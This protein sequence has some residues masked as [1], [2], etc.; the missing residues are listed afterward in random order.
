MAERG[1]IEYFCAN[2][3]A[4]RIVTLLLILLSFENI[5]YGQKSETPKLV[6]GIVVDQM[7]YDYLYRFQ[8]KYGKDGFNK[9]MN[10]GLNCR[11]TRYNYVPT[12][13]GPGHASIYTGTTP[14]NHGIV[15]NDWYDAELKRSKNCVED[16]NYSTVGGA[17]KSGMCSPKNLLSNTIADQLKLTYPD[18]KVVSA[19]IKNRGAIL[20]GGHLSDGSYW[21]DSKTGNFITSTFY[22]DVLPTWVIS[23]NQKKLADEYMKGNW[24]TLY[25]ISTYTESD[26]DD[27]PYEHLMPGKNSPTFPYNL[28]EMVAASGKSASSFFPNTPFANTF[29]TD[30]AME[31][32]LNEGLG[33]DDQTDMLCISYSSPDIIGHAFGPYSKEIEDTYLRLD[34]DLAKLIS[35]LEKEVGKKN[36]TLFITADHA[37]VPVPEFLIDHKLPGGYCYTSERMKELGEALDARFGANLIEAEDNLNVFFNRG[38]ID[39]LKLDPNEVCDYAASV[40]LTWEEV[41]GAYTRQQLNGAGLNDEWMIMIRRGYHKD[42]SGDI[43]FN[44]QPGY[45]PVSERSEDSGKGTSHGSAYAYD[46]HVPLLWYGGGLQKSESFRPIDIT[47]IT[48]TVAHLINVQLP[49]AS[50]GTPIIEVLQPE[51]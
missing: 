45:L 4:M 1:L 51:D 47:D 18:A 43:I 38:K 19:S 12:F 17:E 27:R 14:S 5:A 20:P 21:Y 8:E 41:K 9:L 37:V 3:K 29:L 30:F 36:F 11:N 23:F 24:E 50:T 13:T 33:L 6:V 46:T 15:A 44:L 34:Q 28:S 48:P 35:F 16:L 39:S 25:D 2:Q 40:I 49:N 22:T 10:K 31:A 7:C 32:V 42:E 26:A